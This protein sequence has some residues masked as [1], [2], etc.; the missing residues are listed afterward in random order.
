VGFEPTAVMAGSDGRRIAKN[1]T[2]FPIRIFE[3][4]S[5]GQ[6]SL[7]NRVSH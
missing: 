1:A 6:V 2:G 5:D 7:K 3:D 4:F